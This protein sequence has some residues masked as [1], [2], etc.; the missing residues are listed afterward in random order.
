MKKALWQLAYTFREIFSVNVIMEATM[1]TLD[2]LLEAL[3]YVET[4]YI[5]ESEKLSMDRSYEAVVNVL[6]EK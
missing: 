1:R 4:V 2:M 5:S 3:H 6:I